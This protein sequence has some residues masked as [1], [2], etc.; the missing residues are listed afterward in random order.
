MIQSL[1]MQLLLGS[2]LGTVLVFLLFGVVLHAI[3]HQNIDDEFDKNLLKR[4]RTIGNYVEFERG[5]LEFEWAHY[6]SQAT[7]QP[8]STDGDGYLFH[9]WTADGQLFTRTEVFEAFDLLPPTADSTVPV[10]DTITL[11]DGSRARTVSF[12]FEAIA[13]DDEPPPPVLPTLGITV[14]RRMT[15]VDSVLNRAALTLLCVMGAALMLSALGSVSLI[16]WSLQPLRPVIHQLQGVG[17]GNLN[18][19]VNPGRLPRELVPLID[20]INALL[21]GLE[22]KVARERRFIA[23]AAHELRNPISAV[24]ANLEVGLLARASNETRTEMMRVCLDA[25]GQLQA[26]CERLLSLSGLQNENVKIELQQVDI[27]ELI[28]SSLADLESSARLRGVVFDWDR[29]EGMSIETDP[30]LL[31]VILSNLL[32]NAAAY[33]DAREPVRL[34][35]RIEHGQVQLA[36]QNAIAPGHEL[37][38]LKAVEPFWRADKSRVMSEGHV[39]LG[40]TIAK[41]ATERLHGRLTCHLRNAGRT[42][43][44]E[45]VLPATWPQAAAGKEPG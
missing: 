19:R 18:R 6:D 22:S 9:I 44:V 7:M 36:I 29:Q 2:I 37:D 42:F 15:F 35:T 20:T 26:V 1:R 32:R 10:F 30:V 23:D 39:G 43:V 34:S 21:A 17:A 40:L 45:V 24:R 13:E 16:H 3:L 27:V 31:S 14:A 5:Q 33:A 41:T 4:A 25:A 12:W 38:P 8:I 11:P 28:G